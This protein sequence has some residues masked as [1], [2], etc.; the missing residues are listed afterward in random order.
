MM[1]RSLRGGWFIVLTI[2]I[3][4]MLD[5]MPLPDWVVWL[6]PQWT[7]LVM[8]YWIMALPS[9]IG[10]FYAFCIGVLL[11]L[12]NGTLLGEHAFAMLIVAYVVIKLHQLIRVYPVMQQTLIIFVLVALYRAV[13]YIIQGVSG[14][15]SHTMAYWLTVFVSTIFMALGI[16][17]I[18]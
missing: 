9:Y 11:D 18:A 14:E 10:F 2:F 7:L 12:L 1:N 15:L 16:Y 6:R 4:L 13:I 5:V 17:Y 3:A 8:I